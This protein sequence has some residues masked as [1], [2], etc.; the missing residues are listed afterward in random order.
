MLSMNMNIIMTVFLSFYLPIYISIPSFIHLSISGRDLR[1]RGVATVGAV[2][3][4][5]DVIYEYEYYDGDVYLSIYQ[6]IYLYIY[7]FIHPSIYL[8]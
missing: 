1:P 4:E 7:P 6:S 8:R 2:L 5:E 3:E